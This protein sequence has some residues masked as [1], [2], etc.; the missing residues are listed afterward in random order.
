MGSCQ[1]QVT[2][3]W[4]HSSNYWNQNIQWKPAG[5]ATSIISTS[6]RMQISLLRLWLPANVDKM[7]PINKAYA[8][9][10]GQLMHQIA[11]KHYWWSKS[12]HSQCV[13]RKKEW[14][15]IWPTVTTSGGQKCKFCCFSLF[16]KG[17]WHKMLAK[18]GFMKI[19]L[20][21]VYVNFYFSNLPARGFSWINAKAKGSRLK[22]K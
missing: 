12:I 19:V 18:A 5:E 17:K 6:Y 1:R 3:T 22:E 14:K 7:E 9:L 10:L 2:L 16:S 13:R 21:V 11:D 20:I 4:F 15:A 8:L